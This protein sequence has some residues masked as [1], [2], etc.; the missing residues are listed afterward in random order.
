MKNEADEALDHSVEECMGN[1][2]DEQVA[3]TG[4]REHC[5]DDALPSSTHVPES[6]VTLLRCNLQGEGEGQD[7]V[8]LRWLILPFVWSMMI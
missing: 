3:K 5:S 7:V 4:V 6:G 1:R 2:D 8:V